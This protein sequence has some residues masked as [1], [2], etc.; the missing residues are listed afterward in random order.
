MINNISKLVGLCMLFAIGLGGVCEYS[1]ASDEDLQ[2]RMRETYPNVEDGNQEDVRHY[3]ERLIYFDDADAVYNR[4]PGDLQ[5]EIEVRQASNGRRYLVFKKHLIINGSSLFEAYLNKADGD[6]ISLFR[7]IIGNELAERLKRD[8]EESR[9]NS[10]YFKSSRD[11]E[12]GASWIRC[13][14]YLV[15]GNSKNAFFLDRAAGDLNGYTF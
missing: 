5:N 15:V 4:L 10:V 9:F 13:F 11:F 6:I 8:A 7:E 2:K 1:Q 3:E 12:G 14:F